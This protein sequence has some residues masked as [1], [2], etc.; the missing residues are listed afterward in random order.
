MKNDINYNEL[1]NNILSKIKTNKNN[2]D[3]FSKKEF[4]STRSIAWKIIGRIFPSYRNYPFHNLTIFENLTIEEKYFIKKIKKINCMSTLTNALIINKLCQSIGEK[5]YVNI[6]CWE[7]FSLISGMINTNCN[8]YGVDNFSQFN[9][10]SK[11]FNENFK[12]YQKHN[13]YFYDVDYK[14]FFKNIWKD[15][16]E[17]IDIYFYDANHSYDDQLYSLE[18]AN[19]Y[20][21]NKAIIMIDDIN[22]L[23]VKR[24]TMDFLRNHPN[25]FEILFNKNTSENGH[26]TFWN[27]LMILKKK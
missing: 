26:Y 1:L 25:K 13:H 20:L 9:G 17:K 21:N 8:V 6:G 19:E 11:K 4:E 14:F 16:N 18:I 27:G 22:I 23:D 24:A 10:P 2:F 12:K 7:G 5:N 3:Y 15:K